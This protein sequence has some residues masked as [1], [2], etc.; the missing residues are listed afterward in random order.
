M[1]IIRRIASL[2]ALIG[3]PIAL[4]WAAST[5][6]I[7][8]YRDGPVVIDPPVVPATQLLAIAVIASLP[9][10]VVGLLA[11]AAW[12]GSRA[13]VPNRVA[14]ALA[15]ILLGLAIEHGVLAI[16]ILGR[17]IR[18]WEGAVTLSAPVFVI[19]EMG[20]AAGVLRARRWARAAIAAVTLPVLAWTAFMGGILADVLFRTRTHA[21]GL[22]V[23]TW[24]I[25]ASLIVVGWIFGKLA[26]RRIPPRR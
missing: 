2:L 7:S 16:V 12:R 24:A 4:L 10:A 23:E 20:I 6:L 9:G 1:S 13:W 19:A 3:L 17:G 25:F 11:A 8:F 15:V 14:A 18:G 26:A 5:S 21:P 22:G